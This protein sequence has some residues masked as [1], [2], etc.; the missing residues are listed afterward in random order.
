MPDFKYLDGAAS[1]KYMLAEDYPE[2][3]R[4]A[5]REMHRQVGPLTFDEEGLARRG[6]LVRHLVMPGGLEET[7]AIL[8]WI[9]MPNSVPI[10]MST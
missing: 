10:P 9:A 2:A 1:R 7:R 6:L 4:A 3:A 5:I 8:E